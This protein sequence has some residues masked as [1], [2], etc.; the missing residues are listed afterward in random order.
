MKEI[1]IKYKKLGNIIKADAQSEE[2]ISLLLDIHKDCLKFLEGSE[3]VSLVSKIPE[4]EYFVFRTKRKQSRAVNSGLFVFD[5]DFAESIVRRITLNDFNSMTS[6]EITKALYSIAISFCSSIDL[7]KTG[8]QKTPGTYF[9]YFITHWFA[10][11]LKINPRKQVDVLNLDMSTTLPTDCIFDLG[12]HRPK[13]HLPVK[14]ST[15]ERVIQVWAHQR[16]LDGVYG[17]GRFLGMLVCLSETKVDQSKMEVVEICLPDQ[18]RL[19]QM[20]IAQ[21]KRIYY[22]DVPTRYLALNKIFP[23]IHV[24]PF[25]EFFYE[26]G[27]LVEGKDSRL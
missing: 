7:L 13:I 5:Y 22:L 15:R 14:T 6:D 24:R 19:Y 21:M 12:K 8:D 3:R 16:V 18:W 23:P 4:K 17:T 2:V 25:G 10:K 1:E 20:F 26:I 27:G 9:E 11:M